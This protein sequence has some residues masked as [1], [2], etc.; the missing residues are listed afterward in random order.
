ML[1]S[2]TGCCWCLTDRGEEGNNEGK[3]QR[4]F[5]QTSLAPLSAPARIVRRGWIGGGIVIC[6][7]FLHGSRR[8]G[9]S[10]R[11][12]LG[13]LC[14][15]HH[16]W[17]RRFLVP[18]LHLLGLQQVPAQGRDAD[19]VQ[20]VR[21]Q[22]WVRYERMLVGQAAPRLLEIPDDSLLEQGPL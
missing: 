14:V 21:V 6:I 5:V 4:R 12:M 1:R 11:S 19:G 7:R 10:I 20:L 18:D 17:H 9:R 22:D 3:F 16:L 2:C 15:L 8:L 13:G